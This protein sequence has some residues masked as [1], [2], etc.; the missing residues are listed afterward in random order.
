MIALIIIVLAV[1]MLAL[2]LFPVTISFNSVKSGGK[3]DG[4]LRVSWIIFL[5]RYALKKKQLELF[6]FGRR[7]FSRMSPK[8]KPPV[9]ERKPGRMPPIRDFLN[10]TGPLLRLFKDL[11][12]AF[13]LKCFDVDITFGHSDPAYT[14]ILTGFMH[15]IRGSFPAVK[16]VK[17]APDF[18]GQVLDWNLKAE[19]YVIPVK[20]A[21]PAVKFATDRWVLKVALRNI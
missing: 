20:I 1:S 5:F 19:A 10:I 3:I 13:R 11:F 12:N 2:L 6:V 14:G 4:S 16:K 15:A 17:F 9:K 7:I 18:T 8:R 21:L